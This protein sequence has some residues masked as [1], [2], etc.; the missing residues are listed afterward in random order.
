MNCPDCK[1]LMVPSNLPEVCPDDIGGFFYKEFYCF[2]CNTL[3]VC[4]S[5]SGDYVEEYLEIVEL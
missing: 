3:Y 4:S 1:K 5:Q 2:R